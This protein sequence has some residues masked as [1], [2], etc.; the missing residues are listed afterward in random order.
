LKF[1]QNI[2]AFH[3]NT[4]VTG[5]KVHYTTIPSGIPRVFLYPFFANTAN[6][7]FF[8]TQLIPNHRDGIAFFA[9]KALAGPF[10]ALK[11]QQIRIAQNCACLSIRNALAMDIVL[12]HQL[13]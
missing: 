1:R 2:K 7:L 11:P 13:K 9:K 10:T 4:L 5:N 8:F 12:S 3:K 6:T